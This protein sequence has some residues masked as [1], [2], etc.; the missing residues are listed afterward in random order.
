MFGDKGINRDLVLLGKMRPVSRT[1]NKNLIGIQDRLTAGKKNFGIV[2]TK[3]LQSAMD[4]SAL[5]LMIDYG[6]ERLEKTT[7]GLSDASEKIL[8]IVRK[9]ADMG[10][11]AAAQHEEL[12][13][14]V[15]ETEEEADSVIG[16]IENCQKELGDMLKL[17]DETIGHSVQMKKDMG[18]LTDIISHM[19]E[20]I[21]EITSISSQTN[22]LALNASI[23]AARAGEAGKGFAVVAE[24]IRKLADETKSLTDSMGT[25]VASIH[26]ASEK[27]LSS[28]DTTVSAMES[29]NEGLK[30]VGRQNTENEERIRKIV[31]YLHT[32]GALSQEVCSAFINVENQLGIIS[33]E[34]DSVRSRSEE[35]NDVNESLSRILEPVKRIENDLDDTTKLLG[36]MSG[37]AFYMMENRVF[38]DCVRNAAAAHENWLKVLKE[39]AEEKRIRPLQTDERKCGFGHFYYSITPK[40]KEILEIWKKL[41]GKHSSFHKCA[42]TIMDQI[43]RGMDTDD[44]VREAQGIADELKKNFEEILRIT[45]ES[46]KKQI[47]VFEE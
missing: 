8:D 46:D 16:N 13:T 31:N 19:N 11:E 37:D 3:T 27:S 26:A 29:M 25:F 47:R 1:A 24:E 12:T 23:E 41:E 7:N 21:S 45:E 14:A 32:F 15:S 17:S 43:R 10:S 28:V 18:E 6:K 22:L 42:V 4:V 30:E 44:T 39:M 5:D 35:L 40:N 2:V 38:A 20:V 33:E 9:A 36:S 34:S